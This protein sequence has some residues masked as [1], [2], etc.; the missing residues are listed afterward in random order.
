MHESLIKSAE[1]FI[2]IRVI[3]KLDFNLEDF[4][5]SHKNWLKINKFT[6]DDGEF[7]ILPDAE[8]AISEVVVGMPKHFW[9]LGGLA[10]KL[11]PGTYKFVDSE[12]CPGIVSLSW[13]LSQYKFCRYLKSE[14]PEIRYLVA[15]EVSEELLAI[16]EATKI[17]RDLINTPA[18]DMTTAELANQAVSVAHKFSAS[19]E[20]IVGD[21]LL[22]KGF[23][24]VHAVGR[25]G[26]KAPRLVD[27]EWQ[28]EQSDLPLITLVGKGVCFDTGGL[29]IKSSAGMLGMKKDMG[30]AANILGLAF[31]IMKLKLPVRL[32]V[33]LPIVENSIDAVAYRPSD[34]LTMRDGS[35]VEVTNTDAEGRLILADALTYACEFAPDLLVDM[36]TLTGAARIALGTE[37][38]AAFTDDEG[39]QEVISEGSKY[40]QDPVCFLPIYQPYRQ[41]IKSSIADRANAAKNG[42]G[43]AITAALFLQDFVKK[44]QTWV[45]FDI[46]AANVSNSDGRPEGGEAMAMRAMLYAIKKQFVA[47]S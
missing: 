47:V 36:A 15:P 22:E 20:V 3:S 45:H 11:P 44:D 14:A 29:D 25:A 6:A 4:P 24:A 8:G 27:I 40:W 1:G 30:G 34:V 35:T 32:K 31:C 43:G 13:G 41:M 38:S 9:Q 16:L 33:L 39:L 46:M 17:V 42:Y 18:S 7:C 26:P 19:A 23:P 21:A 37:V 5:V 10:N 28:F 12:V 2:P